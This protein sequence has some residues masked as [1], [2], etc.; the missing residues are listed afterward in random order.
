M[1]KILIWTAVVAFAFV[2]FVKLLPDEPDDSANQNAAIAVIKKP[3]A[4]GTQLLLWNPDFSDAFWIATKWPESLCAYKDCYMVEFSVDV[5]PAGE[6]KTV[7]AEWLLYD[8][9]RKYQSNN[10]EARMLFVSR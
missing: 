7:K 10:A 8:G 2:V 5:I 3:Y 4:P 1:K 6:K 9:N